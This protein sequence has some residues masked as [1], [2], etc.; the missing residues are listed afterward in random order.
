AEAER[1][2][3]QAL[4]IAEGLAAG[5]PGNTTY[6]RDLSVSYNKLADLAVATGQ[7]AEAERLFRQALTI[8]EGLAA[9]EPGNTTYARDLS[10][11]YERL[12]VLDL[13]AGRVSEARE[14]FRRAVGIRRRLYR[15]EPRRIDLAEE[16]AV[17]LYLL[18]DSADEDLEM[19]QEVDAVLAPFERLGVVTAKGV[20]VLRWARSEPSG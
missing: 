18:A 3:R 11:S 9:G 7:A 12:A 15:Q 6:A 2:F 10:I 19:R 20:A 13:S 4:T 5:E 14:Q 1:L 17:T 8:A 16:L